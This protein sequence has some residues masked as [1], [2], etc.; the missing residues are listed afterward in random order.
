M[1][2]IASL[3]CFAVHVYAISDPWNPFAHGSKTFHGA[4]PPKIVMIYDGQKHQGQ[5]VGFEYDKYKAFGFVPRVD[6]GNIT[7]VDA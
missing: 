2:L 7:S 4:A 1:A 6:A 3:L 5:L